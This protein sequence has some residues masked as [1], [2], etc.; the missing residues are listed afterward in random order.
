MKICVRAFVALA[1]LVALGCPATGP[2]KGAI[3]G[4][5]LP[6]DADGVET[7]RPAQLAELHLAVVD[8]QELARAIEREWEAIS[9]AP[10]IIHE[11][12]E[13]EWLATV[14]RNSRTEQIDAAVYPSRLLGELVERRLLVPLPQRLEEGDLFAA[15]DILPLVRRDEI[16]WGKSIYAV[17]LGCPQ[18][19]LAYPA[20]YQVDVE[21]DLNTWDGFARWL[22]ELPADTK[23]AVPTAAGWA[24]ELFLARAASEVR[25]AGQVSTLFDFRTM[26]PLVDRQPY[27]H[28]LDELAALLRSRQAP[29]HLTPGE[30]CDTVL[31]GA[32]VGILW[33]GPG[34]R[35][36]DDASAVPLRFRPLPGS[37]RSL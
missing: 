15:A 9:D 36:G 32:S 19:V 14:R 7:A 35:Q 8:D 21:T 16:V 3:E 33:W 25:T 27:I 24:V 10:L 34:A 1:L 6:S 23:L 20:A 37:A 22:G 30:V 13:E 31:T 26:E 12:N 4:T 29:L 2:D 5:K 28:A 11:V 18:F 17:P